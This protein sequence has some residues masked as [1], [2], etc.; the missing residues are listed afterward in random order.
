MISLQL[1]FKNPGWRLALV[2]LAI[3]SLL[4]TPLWADS[5]IEIQAERFEMDALKQELNAI[6]HVKVARGTMDLY[7]SKAVYNKTSK[8]LDIEGPITLKSQKFNLTCD[9]LTAD[10]VK[11]SVTARGNVKFTFDKITGKSDLALYDIGAETVTLTGSP[12]AWQGNDFISGEK[13]LVLIAQN[14]LVTLGNTKL[15]FSEERLRKKWRNK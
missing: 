11:N 14:K 12:K 3:T 4:F 15:V 8:R 13:I 7:G 10:G 5:D 1:I 2:G 6:G 9:S